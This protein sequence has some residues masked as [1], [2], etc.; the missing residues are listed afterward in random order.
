M[1]TNHFTNK[2]ARFP[3]RCSKI[4][5][6]P[7]SN[8]IMRK[9]SDKA[10]RIVMSKYVISN[11]IREKYREIDK[12]WK[13]TEHIHIYRIAI[14]KGKRAFSYTFSRNESQGNCKRGFYNAWKKISCVHNDICARIIVLTSITQIASSKRKKIYTSY[15]VLNAR[16]ARRICK[17]LKSLLNKRSQSNS[18]HSH[19]KVH[20]KHDDYSAKMWTASH[21]TTQSSTEKV[22]HIPLL[23]PLSNTYTKTNKSY[24]RFRKIRAYKKHYKE[25]VQ[26][27]HFE[28]ILNS[29]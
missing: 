26:K 23:L 29:I 4:V 15:T 6:V 3:T 8:Y 1:E 13:E 7:Q 19:L 14:T 20:G 11:I 25:Q 28:G 16:R 21:N 24:T 12:W 18:R 9:C 17:C 27:I 2:F 10:K 5:P 22:L